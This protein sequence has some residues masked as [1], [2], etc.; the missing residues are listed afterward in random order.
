MSLSS[1]TIDLGDDDDYRHVESL[2][3]TAGEQVIGVRI[4]VN[5]CVDAVA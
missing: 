1:C 5:L 4:I 3:P 2:T